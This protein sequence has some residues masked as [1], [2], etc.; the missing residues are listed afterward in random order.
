MCIL[1]LIQ[2][3]INNLTWLSPEVPDFLAKFKATLT[4]DI[5]PSV[6]EVLC[7]TQYVDDICR[8]WSAVPTLD[9][10]I[11]C[12]TNS[13]EQLIKTHRLREYCLYYSIEDCKQINEWTNR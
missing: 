8:S 3:G 1:Q 9:M 11:E 13:L 12:E 2:D 6:D 5:L 4:S 7:Q 10:F